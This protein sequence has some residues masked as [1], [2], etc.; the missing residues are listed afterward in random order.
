MG[1]RKVPTRISRTNPPNQSSVA[2][3]LADLE[4]RVSVIEHHH[5]V[6]I[7][8]ACADA[9]R[10]IAEQADEQLAETGGERPHKMKSPQPPF[11][12]T[13]KARVWESLKWWGRGFP[14]TFTTPS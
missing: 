11:L 10:Q 5:Q 3:R 7:E 6:L 2:E 4:E 9:D 14:T 13:P 12:T 1:V 8:L